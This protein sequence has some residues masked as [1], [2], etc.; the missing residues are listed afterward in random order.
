MFTVDSRLNEYDNV[1]LFPKKLEL[2]NKRLRDMGMFKDL[3][4]ES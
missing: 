1:I 3:D 4:K 2:A